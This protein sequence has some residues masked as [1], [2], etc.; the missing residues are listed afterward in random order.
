MNQCNRHEF[1]LSKLLIEC[2][3][4]GRLKLNYF[5]PNLNRVNKKICLEYVMQPEKGKNR[6]SRNTK[7]FF[8]LRAFSGKSEVNILFIKDIIEEY[9]L[10]NSFPL[11]FYF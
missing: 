3:L 4:N 5:L 2:V 11:L 9:S 7:I 10:I 8:L 6:S 1:L